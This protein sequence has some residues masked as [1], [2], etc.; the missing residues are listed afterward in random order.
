MTPQEE[1][2]NE[3]HKLIVQ[4]L[5]PLLDIIYGNDADFVRDIVARSQRHIDNYNRANRTIIDITKIEDGL[6]RG[7]VKKVVLGNYTTRF[8]DRRKGPWENWKCECTD[9]CDRCKAHNSEYWANEE[10]KEAIASA[11]LHACDNTVF[12]DELRR[13]YVLFMRSRE[14]YQKL[15][16]LQIALRDILHTEILTVFQNQNQ[17]LIKQHAS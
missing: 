3:R 2:E 8:T 16:P 4:R 7:N 13:S 11:F 5:K 17:Q 6:W 15:S 12:P 1:M 9:Y 14:P 10:I